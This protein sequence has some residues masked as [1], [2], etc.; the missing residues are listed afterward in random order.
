MPAHA[1]D[2]DE[3]KTD[4]PDFVESSDVVGK[5]RVQ[6]ETSFAVERNHAD[7]RRD[8]M[9]TT[10]TLLRFGTGE[11]WELRL[12]TDGRTSLRTSDDANGQTT[13]VHGYS[14]L[15]LGMKWHVRDQEGTNPALG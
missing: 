15:S 9:S 5:G 8:R 4:R 2:E 14:D 3:I 13:T 11:A 7:G 10:P 12:E 6:V 1:E